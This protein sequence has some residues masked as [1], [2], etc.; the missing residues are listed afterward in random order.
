MTTPQAPLACSTRVHPQPLKMPVLSVEQ[1]AKLD[2]YA[3]LLKNWNPRINLVAPATLADLE[4]RHLKD[5]AQLVPHIPQEPTTL[6]DVGSGAGLPGLILAMLLPQHQVTLAERD[7]RKAAFLR[8]AVFS[9]KL[10][11]VTIHDDDVSL[12]KNQYGIITCRA[13]ASLAD[14][15]TLTSPLL[16]PQGHW[17][18]LKGRA[19][20]EELSTCETVFHLTTEQWP[21]I[22]SPESWVVK[23]SLQ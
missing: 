21:S 20:H 1:R 2:E 10:T 22:V 7:K 8:T 5:S 3:K 16:A 11:N 17:L 13:W 9:L 6:L 23:I 14:I 4:E 19:F 18:L 15:L 12:I